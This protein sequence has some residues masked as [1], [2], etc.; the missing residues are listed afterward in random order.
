[1]RLNSIPVRAWIGILGIM[2]AVLCAIFAPLIAP[3]SGS[4]IVGSVWEPRGGDFLLGCATLQFKRLLDERLL[5]FL[6]HWP[7]LRELLRHIHAQTVEEML[8]KLEAFRLVFIER[9]TLGIAP[10]TDHRTQVFQLQKM[11]APFRVDGLQE[12]LLLDRTDR[13]AHV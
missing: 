11:V 7:D 6:R 3:Y 9:V 13:K 5:L 10:E 8:E 12:N 4:Q 2:L 1:M